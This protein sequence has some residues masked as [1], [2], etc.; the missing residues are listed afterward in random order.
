MLRN[1]Y[2]LT[3][4]QKALY[5]QLFE[6]AQKTM[7]WVNRQAINIEELHADFTSSYN[8]LLSKMVSA[9]VAAYKAEAQANVMNL[10]NE[11]I[12]TDALVDVNKLKAVQKSSELDLQ[13]KQ[14]TTRISM[15]TKHYAEAMRATLDNLDINV[16]VSRSVAVSYKAMLAAHS[17]RYSGI[18]LGRQ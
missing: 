9:N 11:I 3:D 7:E 14:E 8:S 15:Y 10:Q 18:V 2:A 1:G 4:Y 17:Q 13:V 6:L 5:S 16:G 12:K